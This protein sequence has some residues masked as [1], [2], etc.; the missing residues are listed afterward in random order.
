MLQPCCIMGVA[1]V[2]CQNNWVSLNLY[3]GVFVESV[4]FTW[5]LQ[6]EGAQ[7]ASTM[8]V[9]KNHHSWWTR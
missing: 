7:E 9:C 6:A 4:F 3:V 1:H 2:K 5:S 8:S